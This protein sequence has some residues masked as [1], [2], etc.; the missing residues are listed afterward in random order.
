MSFTY[1]YIER[2]DFTV[3]MSSYIDTYVYIYMCTLLCVKS[4]GDTCL[5]VIHVILSS[6][7]ANACE[8]SGSKTM[9]RAGRGLAVGQP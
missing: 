9:R 3:I 5:D 1:I 8:P 7:K 6:W 4:T 2:D